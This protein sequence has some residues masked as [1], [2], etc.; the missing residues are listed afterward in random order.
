M[1][2]IKILPELLGDPEAEPEGVAT[3]TLGQEPP[4]KE[5]MEVLDQMQ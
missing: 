2:G 3:V 1:V 4:A 5:T